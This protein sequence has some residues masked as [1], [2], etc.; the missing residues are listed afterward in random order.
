[1]ENSD[2]KQP[3]PPA[4]NPVL[5][6]AAKE[7]AEVLKKHDI[8]GVVQMFIPGFNKY[9]MNLETTWSVVAVDKTGKMRM[10]APLV[11]PNDQEP[12]KKKIMDT[13]RMFT[14]M[15][16][17][18]TKLVG[19]IVQAEVAVRQHFGVTPPPPGPP[20]NLPFKN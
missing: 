5:E 14:N 9:S 16:I 19:V 10:I 3:Q 6:Q 13:I 18:L 2:K 12:A 20:D 7:I 8:A 11:D 17:Y 4:E 15:R 1:M